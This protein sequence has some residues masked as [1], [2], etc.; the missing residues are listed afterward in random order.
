[1]KVFF[2]L[3]SAFAVVSWILSGV[4]FLGIYFDEKFQFAHLFENHSNDFMVAKGI[5]YGVMAIGMTI[6][7]RNL[8]NNK[9][10]KNE[11]T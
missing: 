5:V 8:S 1:M 11:K 6:L 3:F 7:S 10:I 4:V 9:K 2:Y